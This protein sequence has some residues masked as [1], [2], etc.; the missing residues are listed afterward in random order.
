MNALDLIAHAMKAR[1]AA[2]LHVHWLLPDGSEWSAYAATES[3][4]ANW[5]AAKAKLGWVHLADK[6]HEPSAHAAA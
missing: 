4:K 1:A 6:D 5:I 2:G 3:Q